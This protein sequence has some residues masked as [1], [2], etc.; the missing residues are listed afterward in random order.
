MR[1]RIWIRYRSQEVMRQFGL[2]SASEL[3]EEETNIL[4]DFKIVELTYLVL[5]CTYVCIIFL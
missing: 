1:I 2:G 3:S 5:Y 4:F